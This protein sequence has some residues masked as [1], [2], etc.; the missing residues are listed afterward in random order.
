MQELLPILFEIAGADEGAES[1]AHDIVRFADLETAQMGQHFEFGEAV[2]QGRDQRLNRHH[3]AVAGAAIAPGLEVVRLRQEQRGLARSGKGFIFVATEA[4]DLFGF[5]LRLAPVEVRGSRQ[6]RVAPQDDQRVDLPA[7]KV[8]R[9]TSEIAVR[10]R[11]RDLGEENGLAVVAQSRVKQMGQHVHRQRLAMTGED[12]ARPWIG[13]QIAGAFFDPFRVHARRQREPT[14][15]AGDRF[16]LW[17]NPRRDGRRHGH[18]LTSG[19]SQAMVRVHPGQRQQPLDRVKTVHRVSRLLG[20][21]AL[22]EAANHSR[23]VRL[24]ADEIAVERDNDLGLFQ[25]EVGRAPGQAAVGVQVHRFVN[26][27]FGLRK[28]LLQGEQQPQP[29]RRTAPL[30][31]KGNLVAPPRA[32]VPRQIRQGVESFLLGDRVSAPGETLRAIRIVETQDRRLGKEVG[33]TVAV[34]VLRIALDFRGPAFVGFDQQRQC[35]AARRHRG[36]EKLRD[37]VD[38]ALGHSAERKNFLLRPPAARTEQAQSAQQKRG[39]HELDEIAAGNRVGQLA[40]TVRKLPLQPLTELRSVR[41]LIQAAP[42][43]L[44]ALRLWTGRRNGFHR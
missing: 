22:G 20:L 42:I 30:H 25:P 16:V 14:G 12:Q 44:T 31:Q 15:E 26:D 18:H 3:R 9:Q 6:S 13:L 11:L 34:R 10:R 21:A 5:L 4:D 43:F 17:D 41:Q 29:R 27:P 35:T 36:G 38:V 37:A 2:E 32:E 39:R 24:G 8:A 7:R 23:R 28:L 1:V 40:G 19:H 33:A